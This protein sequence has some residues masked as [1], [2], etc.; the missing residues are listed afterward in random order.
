MQPV[1]GDLGLLSSAQVPTV[2]LLRDSEKLHSA[3]LLYKL[4]MRN[5]LLYLFPSRSR[6]LKLPYMLPR[7][8]ILNF[9]KSMNEIIEILQLN[10]N[11]LSVSIKIR[12]VWLRTVGHTTKPANHDLSAF[13]NDYS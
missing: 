9:T 11:A 8:P 7:S 3:C 6:I 10:F 13:V 1:S 4:W 12:R 5:D 2:A